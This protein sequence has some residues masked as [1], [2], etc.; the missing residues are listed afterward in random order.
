MADA[1]GVH[2]LPRQIPLKQAMGMILTG[3]HVPAAEGKELGFVN[4]VV[5]AGQALEGAKRWA[6]LVLECSPMSIRASKQAVYNGLNMGNLEG[7]VRNVYTSQAAMI[8]SEDYIEG[9]KAFSE[10]RKPNWKNR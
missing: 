2:R 8:E 7:A 6:K 4:E 10:K 5:P 1:G 9:P 3:R